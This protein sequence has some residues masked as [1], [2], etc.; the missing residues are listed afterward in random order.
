MTPTLVGIACSVLLLVLIALRVHIGI[1]LSVAAVTGTVVL[2]GWTPGLS[3]LGVSTFDF[4]SSWSLTAIPMFVLMGTLAHHS[5]LT[6]TLFS[7][8][9][10]WLGFLPGGLAIA[11]N[12][13]SAGF[14][15][16]SGSSVAMAGAMSRVAVPEM[17][18]AKYDP[19]LATGIVAVSG[20]WARSSRPASPS[21]STASSWK[22]RSASC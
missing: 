15:A 4:V 6:K 2:R 14:A 18:E 21:S 17:L 5:G 3:L 1:A 13:S 19:G 9:K 11:T 16:A 12:I 10:A 20:T 8:A 22:H 7:A